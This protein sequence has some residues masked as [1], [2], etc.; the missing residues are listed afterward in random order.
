MQPQRADRRRR[1]FPG[2]ARLYLSRG[3]SQLTEGIHNNTVLLYINMLF[4]AM[5]CETDR[6][7]G[8]S[9]CGQRGCSTTESCQYTD[10]TLPAGLVNSSQLTPATIAPNRLT[11][12]LS[13]PMESSHRSHLSHLH[14][15]V[16]PRPCCMQLHIRAD[17]VKPC[18]GKGGMA[19]GY[20]MRS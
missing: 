20:E 12:P 13:P 18:V 17:T 19:F 15:T 8:R 2:A 1:E 7:R 4:L 3:P 10:F 9:Q 11:F 14:A 5:S 16:S 6:C